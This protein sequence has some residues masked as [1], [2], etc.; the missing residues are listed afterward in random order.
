[1]KRIIVETTMDF[2][3]NSMDFIKLGTP[4]SYIKKKNTLEISIFPKTAQALR[5]MAFA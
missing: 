3:Q 4:H 1:M 5:Y 2:F